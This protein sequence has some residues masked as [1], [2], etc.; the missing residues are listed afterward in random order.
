MSPVSIFNSH[1]KLSFGVVQDWWRNPKFRFQ[2]NEPYPEL[3]GGQ[4]IRCAR[5]PV[6][7]IRYIHS[8]N[9]ISSLTVLTHLDF[10]F[11]EH[12]SDKVR[13]SSKSLRV[14]KKS[15][16][17][18]SRRRSTADKSALDLSKCDVSCK[19]R[20]SMIIVKILNIY[21]MLSCTHLYHTSFQYLSS[22]CNAFIAC[23]IR[24]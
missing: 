2:V 20:L 4:N 16:A 5:G 23:Y 10:L 19:I 18:D 17:R 15:W 21:I 22:T 7:S 1:L 3:N 8:T 14:S 11:R 24:R 12:C 9:Q 6:H 13:D